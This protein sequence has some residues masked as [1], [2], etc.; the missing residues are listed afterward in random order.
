MSS[1]FEIGTSQNGWRD[2]SSG[3]IRNALLTSTSSRPCSRG[4]PIE[5][6]PRPPRRRGGR[7]ATPTPMP[8]ERGSI[9]GGGGPDRARQRVVG[10][11]DRPAGD[12]DGRAAGPELECASLADPSAGAG[13]DGDL[14]GEVAGSRVLLMSRLAQSLRPIADRHRLDIGAAQLDDGVVGAASDRPGAD[15]VDRPAP[16]LGERGPGGSQPSRERVGLPRSP[17]APAN[18]RHPATS[19]VPKWNGRSSGMAGPV[20]RRL[21]GE[22]RSRHTGMPATRVT[23]G[24][25]QRRADAGSR[26]AM[27]VTRSSPHAANPRSTRLGRAIRGCPPCACRNGTAYFAGSTGTTSRNSSI[28]CAVVP[29]TSG[30][31][32]SVPAVAAASGAV[33]TTSPS[34]H[35]WNGIIPTD[36]ARSVTACVWASSTSSTEQGAEARSASATPASSSVRVATRRAV[37]L[38]ER[39]RGR[40]A[41]H[42]GAG[43]R[44]IRAG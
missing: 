19:S 43:N 28:S 7:S 30:I 37:G 10:L 1:Q 27:A 23:L 13:D 22:R 4:D 26:S 3:G 39:H 34:T 21:P 12:V 44:Q 33:G 24:D 5:Q 15:R 9:S 29:T 35:G 2:V 18:S 32:A 38:V 6:R 16:R 41:E 42:D 31:G 36:D 8:P 11:G 20:L 17:S 14:A 25:E 40:A